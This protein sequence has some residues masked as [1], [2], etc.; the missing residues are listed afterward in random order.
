M[1]IIFEPY[2]YSDDGMNAENCVKSVGRR[3]DTSCRFL[4][5]YRASKVRAQKSVEKG[6]QYFKGLCSGVGFVH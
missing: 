6:F 1:K 4:R 2:F 3:V 5:Q